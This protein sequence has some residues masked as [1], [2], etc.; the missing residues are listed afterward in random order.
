MS[1]NTRKSLT[2]C[3]LSVLVITS[4]FAGVAEALASRVAAPVPPTLLRPASL[5]RP[6]SPVR[7]AL[8]GGR[9][10]SPA[11]VTPK[12]SV[13]WG[14]A[15]AQSP[16]GEVQTLSTITPPTPSKVLRRASS[17]SSTGSA[18]RGGSVPP[19]RGSVPS[20]AADPGATVINPNRYSR[21]PS[22]T[23]GTSALLAPAV[24]EPSAAATLISRR[25]TQAGLAAQPVQAQAPVLRPSGVAV[26]SPAR[27]A[28]IQA[29]APRAAAVGVR[30]AQAVAA[31]RP[32]AAAPSSGLRA[33]V[34]SALRGVRRAFSPAKR[35]APAAQ[36][37]Q[38]SGAK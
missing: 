14:K 35:R 20:A 5:V 15:Q 17:V 7:S 1:S 10:A 28:A 22:A 8:R 18:E 29:A 11:G 6:A 13:S 26:Q 21:G 12:R 38:S 27:P 9:A 2:F 24:A 36:S 30:S 16:T 32:A 4:V 37:G 34:S 33:Q 25:N 3:N 31:P 19:A 23:T